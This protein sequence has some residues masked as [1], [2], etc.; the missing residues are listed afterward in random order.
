MVLVFCTILDWNYERQ[1]IPAHAV[2][3]SNGSAGPVLNRSCLWPASR[4][5]FFGDNVRNSRPPDDCK[6]IGQHC[7]C[8][9]TIPV[10][11]L[12]IH[13]LCNPFFLSR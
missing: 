5:I 7:L 8:S 4:L 9:G 6:V 10:N 2:T 13:G 3:L 12:L 1:L 11:R